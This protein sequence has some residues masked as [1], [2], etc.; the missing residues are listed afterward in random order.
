M[1]SVP[2]GLR[3]KN[4]GNIR[5]S[6]PPW[7]GAVGENGGFVV[8]DT[9]ANGL[10]A[11]GKQLLAYYDKRGINTIGSYVD[12]QGVEHEGAINRWAPSNENH[13]DNYIAFMCSPAVLNC[14]PTDKFDFHDPNFLYWAMTGIG[15]EEQGHD[16]FTQN[17][18]D[19][20]ITAGVAAALG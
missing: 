13:T 6:N 17:V 15:E 16:A 8:F 5:P 11:L 19:A 9:M 1:P 12:D 10:R 3:N 2:L 20:D 4:P 18:S 14:K 7:Q